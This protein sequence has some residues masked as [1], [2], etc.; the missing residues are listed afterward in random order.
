MGLLGTWLVRLSRHPAVDVLVSVAAATGGYA[1]AH[2]IHVS[3]PLAMVV[4]GLIFGRRLSS[5]KENESQRL[6]LESFWN[7]LDHLLNAVLFTLMG[8]V[9]LALSHRTDGE[10]SIL[11]ALLAIPVV[12]LAR[13]A[14]VAFSLPLTKLRCGTPGATIAILSWGGLRG[15]ISIALALSLS[16]NQSKDLI[17][18][19]TFAVVAFSTIV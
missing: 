16:D 7:S 11:A 12:L 2:G 13:V 19:M 3:G 9:L 4:L 1:L 5:G 10:G 6:H 18:H 8:I 15:G 17:L 14:S